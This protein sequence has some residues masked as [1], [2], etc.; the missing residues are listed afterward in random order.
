MFW[1]KK[2]KPSENGITVSGLE[3]ASDA[4]LHA[5]GDEILAEMRRR[6]W[7]AYLRK[8]TMMETACLSFEKVERIG[9]AKLHASR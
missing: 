3:V 5:L 2:P 7:S 8:G 4:Q 6:G 9:P 1:R